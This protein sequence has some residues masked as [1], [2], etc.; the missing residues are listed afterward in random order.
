M[1][2]K[3]DDYYNNEGGRY[4]VEG[5]WLDGVPHGVCI[6]ENDKA[7][8]VMTFTNGIRTGGP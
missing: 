8:G 4:T 6:A 1:L 5:E 3:K 7:R 2:F